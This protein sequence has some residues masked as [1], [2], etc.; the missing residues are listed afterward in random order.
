MTSDDALAVVCARRQLKQKMRFCVFRSSLYV[1]LFFFWISFSLFRFCYT[2]SFWFLVT[3]VPLYCVAGAVIAFILF[4]SWICWY[5]KSPERP[6]ITSLLSRESLII[7]SPHT[8]PGAAP[9]DAAA[10]AT[11]RLSPLIRICL[12]SLILLLYVYHLQYTSFG[13]STG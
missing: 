2:F 6:Y 11:T 8:L 7:N 13:P 12:Y 9:P 1:S 3:R 4:F 5:K 10:A